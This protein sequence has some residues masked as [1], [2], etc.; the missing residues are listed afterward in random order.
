MLNNHVLLCQTEELCEDRIP[1][2]ECLNDIEEVY[3]LPKGRISAYGGVIYWQSPAE[4][5]QVAKYVSMFFP[6][7]EVHYC[8]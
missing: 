5:W 3:A 4:R 8:V 1:V 2:I 7:G 6:H